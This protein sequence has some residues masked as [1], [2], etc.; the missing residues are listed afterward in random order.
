MTAEII[1]LF[2][3][4]VILYAYAGYPVLL[5]LAARW[6][7]RPV[8]KGKGEPFVSIVLS[9]FNEEAAIERKLVNLLALN[10]PAAKLEILI[11]SDGGSDKTDEIV[12][13]FQS[14]QIRFFRFVKNLGKPQVLSS[15]VR[16]AHG[17]IL[18]FTDAR[19]E[20][21]AMAVRFLTANFSDPEV[22]CVSGE[23]F[24]KNGEGEAGVAGGM[25]AYWRYEKFLRKTESLIGSMLGAT[26]A[27]YAIRRELF[28][29]LPPDILVDDMYIP[30]AIVRRGKR[31]VFDSEAV[32][33]DRRS[34]KGAQEFRR[35]VRTLAGNY[36][37]FAWM[38]DLF[39]PFKSPVA[40][41]LFSHKFLRLMVPFCLAGLLVSNLFMLNLFFFRAALACQVLFYGLAVWE[42]IL[43]TSS[44]RKGPGYIPYTFCLLN[45]AAV[46]GLFKFLTRRQQVTWG[47]AYLF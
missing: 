29:K 33:Y 42:S 9:A 34:Q 45:Y 3:F 31:A 20:L 4:S 46:V 22:G 19:Q 44:G 12:S 28:P 14:P 17:S 25:D 10:Y 18:V 27:I 6:M 5:W 30:L 39:V 1:F 7:A 41:Q 15:L 2:L 43:E 38:P 24:F 32:A 13:R 35:K 11:G 26:G 8:R 47:K 36:Q 16:E 23:L 40:W 37:I 21:D